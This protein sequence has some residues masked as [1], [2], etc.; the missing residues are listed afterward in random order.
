MDLSAVTFML[1]EAILRKMGTEVTHHSVTG[2]FGDHTGSGDGKAEAIAID[3]SGLRNWKGDNGQAIN[4]DV[5][6]RVGE[7]GNGGAHRFV[8]SAQDIDPVD[9]HGIDNAHRRAEVRIRGEVVINF[10]A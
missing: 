9:F 8:R 7:G 5:I 6:R 3:N 2:N 4:Q 10:F 1:A